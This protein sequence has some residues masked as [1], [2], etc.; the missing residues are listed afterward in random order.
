MTARDLEELGEQGCE[1]LIVASYDRK[2]CDWRPFLRYAVNFHSSP[3]PDGRGPYPSVRAI[4][5]NRGFWGVTCHRLTPDIDRGE[6][7]AAEQFPLRPDECHESLDLKIQMAAKRLATR[8]AGQFAE[9]WDLAK[10]QEEGSYWKKHAL[11]EHIIDFKKPVESIMRHIRAFGAIGSL[12]SIGKTWVTV[13]RAV[14]WTEKHAHAPGVVV[15]V[16]NQ[17]IVVAA[18]DGYVGILESQL[19]PS[20]V[21]VQMLADL[22]ARSQ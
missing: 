21:I 13:K 17:S 8:V 19:T 1:A 4:L 16:F 2:I 6:I 20:H 18:S 10:P 5:E 11:A 7:L 14:G 12:A 22:N 9:L 15:H 3:L